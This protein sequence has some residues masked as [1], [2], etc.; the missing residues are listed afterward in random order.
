[1]RRKKRGVSGTG[2]QR[3]EEELHDSFPEARV[4]R[5]DADTTTSRYSFENSLKSS[6][7]ASM[8]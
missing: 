8:I 1:M 4:L 7:T 2:T 5:L 3:L 6:Q